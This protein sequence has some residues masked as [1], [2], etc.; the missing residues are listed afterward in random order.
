M[1]GQVRVWTT[2]EFDLDRRMDS[3]VLLFPSA[4]FYQIKTAFVE[5][6]GEPTE[7]RTQE[8]QNR[9]GARFENELLEWKGEKVLIDLRRYSSRVTESNATIR[10]VEGWRARLERFR[11]KAKEGKKDL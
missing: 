10:T 4:N 9:M 6:Y 7:R 8:I 2:I 11:E 3:V 1:I 5:R